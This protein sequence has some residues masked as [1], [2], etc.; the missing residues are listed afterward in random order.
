MFNTN[1]SQSNIRSTLPRSP[2]PESSQPRFRAHAPTLPTPA[3]GVPHAYRVVPTTSISANIP[4]FDHDSLEL[5]FTPP[6]DRYNAPKQRLPP[7]PSQPVKPSSISSSCPT[8]DTPD[9][10]R[11]SQKREI[12]DTT[13]DSKSALVISSLLITLESHA[14]LPYLPPPQ[15]LKTSHTSSMSAIECEAVNLI[16]HLD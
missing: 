16:A 2:S 8:S 10:F 11:D 9:Q 13:N 5:A 4:I 15:V 1:K 14:A 12:R 3:T 7:S 6:V